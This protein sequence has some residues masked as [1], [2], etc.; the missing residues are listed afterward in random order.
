MI[1]DLVAS[2]PSDLRFIC[3]PLELD[4]KFD[5]K[6]LIDLDIGDFS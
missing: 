5:D 6:T 2:I 1:A 4:D 3:G